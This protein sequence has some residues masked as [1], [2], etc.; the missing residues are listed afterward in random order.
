[1]SLNNRFRVIIHE[2]E[3]EREMFIESD[4]FVIGR[5]IKAEVVI[6][7]DRLS[8]QHVQVSIVEGEI[9][10]EDL[11][12]SNGTWIENKKLNPKTKISYKTGQRLKMGNVPEM[13]FNIEYQAKQHKTRTGVKLQEIL[14]QQ[15]E[16][17]KIIQLNALKNE[18]VEKTVSNIVLPQLKAAGAELSPPISV[19]KVSKPQPQ[20]VPAP[21]PT[22][23]AKQIPPK[24]SLQD[25]LAILDVIGVIPENIDKVE[26]SGKEKVALLKSQAENNLFE[27]IKRLVGSEA[28]EIRLASLEDAKS[29]RKKAEDYALEVIHNA[30]NNAKKEMQETE[31]LIAEKLH[32]FKG[33][34]AEATNNL[35]S[36]KVAYQEIESEIDALRHSEAHYRE[37]LDMLK[38]SIEENQT[39]V[40]EEKNKLQL[41]Q[42]EVI[43]AKKQFDQKIQ[44]LS[45]EERRIKAQLET[46]LAE[47]KL[48]TTQVFA[49]AER[50]QTQKNLLEPEIQY[51][52]AEKSKLEA[53]LH[54][55]SSER[56]RNEEDLKKIS[57]EY[58][59]AREELAQ[60]RK[61]CDKINQEIEVSRQ[62]FLKFQ[63]E[64][65][66]RDE[67]LK[68]KFAKSHLLADEI[69]SKARSDAD[70]LIEDSKLNAQSITDDAQEGLKRLTSQREKLIIEIEKEKIQQADKIRTEADQIKR[71]IQIEIDDLKRK[72]HQ[73]LNDTD[74]LR[75]SKLQDIEKL[76]VKAQDEFNRL[77]K[78][79]KEEAQILKQIAEKE[80]SK[81]VDGAKNYSEDSK[82]KTDT[83]FSQLVNEIQEKKKE[84]LRIHQDKVQEYKKQLTLIEEKKATIEQ[85]LS[86]IEKVREDRLADANRM[87]KEMLD[88][89]QKESLHL[90]EKSKQDA[91]EIS[92]K[93]ESEFN[94]LKKKQQN[95]LAEL[96]H[97][98]MLEIK[99]I[100]AKEEQDIITKRNERAKAV[101]T[102]IYALLTTEMFKARNKML[103]EEF[104]QAFTKD[105]KELVMDTLLDKST[106]DSS[107]L[108]KILKSSINS[109]DKD[110]AFWKKFAIYGGSGIFALLLLIIFP[111]IITGPKNALVRSFQDQGANNS[112]KF[113]EKVQEA[114]ERLVYNPETT[115]EFKES[116]VDNLLYTTDYLSKKQAQAFHDKWVLELNDF[117][118]Y[119]LDVKDTTLIKFVSYEAALL[120]ELLKIKDQINPEDPNPKI[121]EMRAKE[122]E[123]REKLKFIFDDG[124]KVDKF[125]S[126]SE[127]FWNNFYN[128]RKPAQKN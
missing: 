105:I 55:I 21:K 22:I 33:Q 37:K 110:K 78:E 45:L 72:K 69:I 49:E 90:I 96:K 109:K 111:Q 80:A 2:G 12:S 61:H 36:I 82:K 99:E 41:T 113:L 10:V 16:S 98:E 107:K 26:Q 86:N 85:E 4:S 63:R 32:Y 116:Y 24:T 97:K 70:K 126:Y 29:I 42:N 92:Q 76:E 34:E 93:A 104:I 27:Q 64:L 31:V 66:A 65:D 14:N 53:E 91:K 23:V 18:P 128:P 56:R 5:S 52:K 117:F 20:I 79:G 100:K 68:Q 125:Y 121:D 108:Q 115:P 35:E 9:F 118:I 1:M 101:S 25:K 74:E 6:N 75:R 7:D 43:E 87:A 15:E 48:K 106:S 120:K 3:N 95:I 40:V 84:A 54:T 47:A 73:L 88:K 127:Q 83:M 81:L 114:R 77:V 119:R 123:F 8:R 60:A 124:G 67:E 44:D 102:N 46:E 112:D 94:D 17:S 59:L 103:S 11:G 38:Q 13:F 122:E 62:D 89:A 71:E 19:P 50:A 39:K 51:L 30:K 58:E 28:E 57:K